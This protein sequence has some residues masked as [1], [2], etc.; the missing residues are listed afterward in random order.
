MAESD[1]SISE[2]T[3]G[4]FSAGALFPAIQPSQ[5]SASGYSNVKMSG[6]DIGDGIGQLQFP[7]RLET[8]NKSIFGAINEAAKSIINFLPID[9]ASGSLASFPDGANGVPLQS[10]IL[11]VKPYQAGT[12]DPSP[13][14]ERPISGWTQANIART[15]SNLING[16]ILAEK[17]V[18]NGATIDTTNKTVSYSGQ[19]ARATGVIFNKFKPNTNYT[20]MA[21]VATGSV[22][23]VN[24]KVFYT[25]GT[26]INLTDMTAET[27]KTWT[28]SNIDY[29]TFEWVTGTTILYYE[30]FGIFEGT[31][32]AADFKPYE[33]ATRTAEFEQTIYGAT[34]NPLTGEGSITHAIVNMGNM[35]YTKFDVAQGSLFRTQI[36]GAKTSYD[37]DNMLCSIY[38]FSTK[39]NRTNFT[40]SIPD[41]IGNIDFINNSYSDADT[42]KTAMD[43]QTVWYEL[44]TPVPITIT[45]IENINTLYGANNIFQDAGDISVTYRADIGL[46]I[47][48]KTA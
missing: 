20:I 33:G 24:I 5:Q 48:K 46:Y 14:N 37:T 36:A 44:A 41:N 42:F 7:L 9:T 31:L 19:I 16:E 10:L 12:G 45:P 25:N 18:T 39:D 28:S 21:K 4:T 6:A 2:M 40:F 1:I 32:T 43:G 8:E 29:V 30:Q 38:R 34:I 22:G 13:N 15:G 17:L 3:N 27:M 35:S 26:N 23:N 11:N 47:A